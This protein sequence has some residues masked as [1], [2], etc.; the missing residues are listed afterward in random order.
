[1]IAFSERQLKTVETKL[2]RVV[3]LNSFSFTVIERASSAYS[4]N[5]RASSVIGPTSTGS[6]GARPTD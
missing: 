5:S 4:R 2:Q 6:M 1:M 3:Q